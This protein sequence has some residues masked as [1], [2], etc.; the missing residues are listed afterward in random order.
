MV[1]LK[2]FK[3]GKFYLF[4]IML[5]SYGC[6][7]D[8]DDTQSIIIRNNS[9]EQIVFYKIYSLDA[10]K[11]TTLSEE[12][13]W[14]N[15]IEDFYIIKPYDNK[16]VTEIK[17]NIEYV[18]SDGWYQYYIFNYDSI[19]TIP[20]ERIHDEYI[21]AKRVDFDTWEELEDMDFTVTYP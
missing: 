17:S 18:L 12:F 7:H 13:P 9:G 10:A 8:I 4:L 11:D 19:N 2:H 20:W 16:E 6:P 5:L 21:V 14:G 1:K 15:S 3:K